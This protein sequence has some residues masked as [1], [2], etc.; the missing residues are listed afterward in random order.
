MKIIDKAK[1]TGKK[2]KTKVVEKKK[3]IVKGGLIAGAVAVIGGIAAYGI[4]KLNGDYDEYDVEQYDEFE[5]VELTE[6]DPR[7]E[8]VED[9]NEE[10]E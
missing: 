1:E 4:N 10:E 6:L 7:Q 2:I 3:S 8:V 9:E 5:E